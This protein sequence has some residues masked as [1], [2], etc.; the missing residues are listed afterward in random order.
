MHLQGAVSSS[1]NTE[2]VVC[3]HPPR[4]RGPQ[5]KDKPMLYLTLRFY[6]NERESLRK[7]RVSIVE[8]LNTAPLVWGFT[9]GPLAGK[10]DLSFTV[11]SQC[12]E[13]LRNGEVDVAIIP[14]IEYQRMENVVALPDMA[15]AAKGQ[16]R[17]LL[18]V[19]K[20]P[21][22][23]AK[24]IALD[25]S[26]R[27]TVALTRILAK[28]HW[29]ISPE[30]V[31]AEPDVPEMLGHADA[32]LVI[33]DPALS[34]AIKMDTLAS[35]SP[36]SGD[37]CQG[38]PEDMP[39]P[40]FE[41]LFVYDVAHQWHELTGKPCVLAL[42]VGRRDAITPEVV[43]DFQASKQYG[44]EHISEIASAAA[45]TL[46]LPACQLER[47]LRKNIQFHLDEEN[48]AGLQLFFEKAAE[49]GLIPQARP[50]EFAFAPAQRLAHRGD[51]GL[52]M[53]RS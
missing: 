22:E 6:A 14:A 36:T 5:P 35:K 24:R 20:R 1:V 40:G 10:Y 8:F 52:G 3:A 26:S 45:T 42:W 31:D 49:I 34:I 2:K 51:G 13:A 23:L 9:N 30:F 18:V 27:S 48:L 7:L 43:A 29:R 16:V 4:R 12:A 50:I 11:P 17:S 38:D 32:A 28:D 25:V 46:G 47:Y 41:S 37:C 39:V 33:G 19:A 21:I 15:I 53:K 44:L